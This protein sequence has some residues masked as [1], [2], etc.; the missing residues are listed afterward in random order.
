MN[1]RFVAQS[2][3]DLKAVWN[4]LDTKTCI[5]RLFGATGKDAR[6]KAIQLAKRLNADKRFK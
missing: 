1:K 6:Y 4:V 5:Y 3:G 2:Q